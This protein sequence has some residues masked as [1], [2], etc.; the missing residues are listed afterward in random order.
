MALY[1]EARL[2]SDFTAWCGQSMWRRVWLGLDFEA[3]YCDVWQSLSGQGW[4]FGAWRGG[5]QYFEVRRGLD[6]AALCCRARRGAVKRGSARISRFGP[7]VKGGAMSG[8]E[9]S[10]RRG[11][12]K[13]GLLGHSGVRVLRQCFVRLCV[14]Q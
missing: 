3:L 7:V 6:F 5:A 12:V 13:R 9:F 14:A 10:V 4:D 11:P 8:I 1:R 2:G